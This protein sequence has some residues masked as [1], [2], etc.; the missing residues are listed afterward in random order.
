MKYAIDFDEA[1]IMPLN[2]RFKID[3]YKYYQQADSFAEAKELLIEYWE[4]VKLR[5]AITLRE[6][7]KMKEIV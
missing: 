5:T 7:K 4:A 3:T 1:S 2:S 6:V